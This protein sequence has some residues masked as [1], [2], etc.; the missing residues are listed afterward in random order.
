MDQA[1]EA[2]KRATTALHPDAFR[3]E[4]GGGSDFLTLA[5]QSPTRWGR[6]ASYILASRRSRGGFPSTGL[7][8]LTGEVY[9]LIGEMVVVI[10]LGRSSL[11]P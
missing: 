2:L 9:L 11:I 5:S 8:G 4:L 6:A 3:H 7:M 10:L 1:A